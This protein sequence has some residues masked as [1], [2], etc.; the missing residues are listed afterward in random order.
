MSYVSPGSA[1][2][3]RRI[4]EIRYLIFKRGGV[5]GAV[6]RIVYSWR[7]RFSAAQV[8]IELR[9]RWPL[10][11]PGQYQV[12]DCLEQMERRRIIECVLFKHSKIYQRIE[13]PRRHLRVRILPECER[14]ESFGRVVN[15]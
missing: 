1:S 6:R 14:D 10:L 7:F 12:A 13:N 3:A 15:A 8:Q 5:A 11:V 9:Q 4:A 2:E